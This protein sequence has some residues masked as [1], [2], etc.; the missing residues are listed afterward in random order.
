MV[1]I[2]PLPATG[3]R[4]E[5]SPGEQPFLFPTKGQAISFAV[6]WAENHPPCE[7]R[8]YGS[9]GDLERSMTFPDGGYRR[10]PA[11]DRRRIQV[12]IAFPDRRRQERRAQA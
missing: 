10:L 6:A 3:W 7:V 1:K 8:L 11:A 5:L 4:V 12:D 9:V 2:S